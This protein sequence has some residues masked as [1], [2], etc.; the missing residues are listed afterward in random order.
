[1]RLDTRNL[2]SSLPLCPYLI[3]ATALK[4]L[5]HNIQ[6]SSY[7]NKKKSDHFII[8]GR[9]AKA[10]F[11]A[12]MNSTYYYYIRLHCRINNSYFNIFTYIKVIYNYNYFNMYSTIPVIVKIVYNFI[13]GKHFKI[14]LKLR[15]NVYTDIK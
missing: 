5:K 10:I 6:S 2:P 3:V 15:P 1:M 13:P 8:T 12:K 9:Y 11:F 14:N 4:L 7:C